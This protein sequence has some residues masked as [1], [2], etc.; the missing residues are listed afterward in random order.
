MGYFGYKLLKDVS[1]ERAKEKV[2]SYL[3][4]FEQGLSSRNIV[5]HLYEGKSCVALGY[6]AMQHE[7]L[8]L[9]PI[10]WQLGCVWMDVDYLD[11]DSWQ[12]KLFEGTEHR[13]THNVNPWAE[14]E[15]PTVNMEHVEYR[16][17]RICELWPLQADRI[18]KH[19]LLW[20]EPSRQL[21]VTRWVP[22][23]GK[24]YDSDKHEYGDAEQIHDFLEAFGIGETSRREQIVAGDL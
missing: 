6:G 7:G 8:I 15:K 13:C 19:L 4:Q 1:P 18:R 22:R 12:V 11:G 16:I 24:A 20:K 3:R 10:G 23:I 5:V 2:V 14:H 21:G 9:S 17:N